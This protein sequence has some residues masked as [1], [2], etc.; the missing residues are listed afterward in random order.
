MSDES[1]CV[2]EALKQHARKEFS[3]GGDARDRY[4]R[5]QV[6]QDV[7]RNLSACFVARE[8]DSERV[9]GFYTLSACHV[10]LDDLPE[11]VVRRLPR[12]PAVPA[13]RIGRLAVDKAFKGRGL[14][15]ALLANAAQRAL[16]TG[17]AVFALVV[18]AKDEEAVAFYRHN[19]FMSLQEER[20][21]FLP[22]KGFA[23]RLR[24]T[25]LS[26]YLLLRRLS[27]D[28]VRDRRDKPGS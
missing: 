4:I 25:R 1:T 8:R 21:L 27:L 28:A 18:D 24:K 19:G 15:G 13:A 17:I 20:V 3:C 23:E 14:G 26:D 11:E 2:V 5:T 16:G 22:L 6:S 10:L 9:A 7:R 12:Y